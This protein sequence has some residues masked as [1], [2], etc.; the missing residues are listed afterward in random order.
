MTL[1][2]R[3]LKGFNS[4]AKLIEFSKHL[5]DCIELFTGISNIGKLC[6]SFVHKQNI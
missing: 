3:S 2:I 5:M 6:D 1:D 4:C